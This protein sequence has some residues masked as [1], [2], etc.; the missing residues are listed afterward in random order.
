[1]GMLIGREF[2]E[3]GYAVRFLLDL[4][5]SS[6]FPSCQAFMKLACLLPQMGKCSPHLFFKILDISCGLNRPPLGGFFSFIWSSHLR[7]VVF[8]WPLGNKR[9]VLG[10]IGCLSL[11]LLPHL[12]CYL[13]L[14]YF[15][16][17]V[18]VSLTTIFIITWST[19]VWTK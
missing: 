17:F 12:A 15:L 6:P 16:Y 19:L 2:L 11:H 5:Y 13:I 7:V 8:A 9:S 4:P 10:S 3:E 1:M 18:L 14:F